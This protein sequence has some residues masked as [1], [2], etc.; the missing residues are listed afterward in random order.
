M[1]H[2]PRLR[3]RPPTHPPTCTQVEDD[4][5]RKEK[6]VEANIARLAAAEG[7]LERALLVQ[8]QVR[9]GGWR[10]EMGGWRSEVNG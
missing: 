7:L 9:R 10:G 3:T 5:L 2:A 6:E 1:T 8:K 4:A